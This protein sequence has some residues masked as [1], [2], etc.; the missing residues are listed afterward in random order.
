M[1]VNAS[2]VALRLF[3]RAMKK[4]LVLAL[5]S[6]GSVSAFG[7]FVNGSVVVWKQATTDPSGIISLSTR[8]S[9]TGAESATLALSI[10][11]ESNSASAGTIKGNGSAMYLAGF[12]GTQGKIASINFATGNVSYALIG[13]IGAR[14]V[15]MNGTSWFFT[16]SSGLDRFASTPNFNNSSSNT[17][18]TVSS[19]VARGATAWGNDIFFTSSSNSNSV[20]GLWRYNGTS[21]TRVINANDFGSVS[22]DSFH[23]VVLTADGLSAYIADARSG[24]GGGIRKFTRSS[25]TVD[26][27]TQAYQRDIAGAG[28]RYLAIKEVVG[29]NE[30]FVT[31]TGGANNTFRGFKENGSGISATQ[32]FSVAAGSGQTFRGVTVVPEPATMAALGLGLAGIAARRRRK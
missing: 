11:G 20:A 16:S 15:A 21:A 23:D 10:S 8:S 5:G 30:I 14:S 6:L 29:G 22:T 32:M 1:L 26:T 17:S 19:T 4:L 31:T 24:A 7:Q 13:T 18:T 25:T 12:D 9:A 3:L 27:W 2:D 28:V